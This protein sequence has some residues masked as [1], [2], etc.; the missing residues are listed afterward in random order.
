MHAFILIVKIAKIEIL[1]ET[2]HFNALFKTQ[3]NPIEWKLAQKVISV[4]NQLL[5]YTDHE[6]QSQAEVWAVA[7]RAWKL[8]I[9]T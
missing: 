2:N 4:T 5:N 1:H 9:V 7:W 8:N 6:L 3:I